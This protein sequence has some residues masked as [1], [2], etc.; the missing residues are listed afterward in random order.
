M[1]QAL[2]DARVGEVMAL[3]LDRDP[4]EVLLQ[5]AL[6]E[7]VAKLPEADRKKAQAQAARWEAGRA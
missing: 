3:L 6:D 5:A 4:D 7:V 1:G 2:P